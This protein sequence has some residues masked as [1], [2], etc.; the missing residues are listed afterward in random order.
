VYLIYLIS[1]FHFLVPLHADATQ[2]TPGDDTVHLEFIEPSYFGAV[3]LK[4]DIDTVQSPVEPGATAAVRTYQIGNQTNI[5]IMLS[6]GPIGVK[7]VLDMR[8]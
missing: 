8:P 3:S 2:G 1:W 6:F 5:L 7:K 4:Y